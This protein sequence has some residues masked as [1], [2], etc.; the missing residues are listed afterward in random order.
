MF[1]P[2]PALAAK[3]DIISHS[4]QE[5]ILNAFGEKSG[6]LQT[7]KEVLRNISLP[8]KFWLNVALPVQLGELQILCCNSYTSTL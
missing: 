3:E 6:N 1:L 4:Y 8:S 5:A 7:L 2:A